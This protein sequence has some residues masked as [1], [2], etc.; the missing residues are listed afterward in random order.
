M[1]FTGQA[2]KASLLPSGFA[3]VMFDL[4]ES[5]VNKF[6]QLTLRELDEA[7]AAVDGSAA[8]G[9]VF[10]SAK[11]T[12]IV[13]ADITEFGG[14]F[15]QGEDEVREWLVQA[16]KVF[17]AVEDLSVPSVATVRRALN[18]SVCC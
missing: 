11:S 5:S 13:G 14:L 17:N 7:I 6:D 8:R 3:C 16:N 4:D 12:F 18:S 9:V 15:S 1:L 10:A 2:I